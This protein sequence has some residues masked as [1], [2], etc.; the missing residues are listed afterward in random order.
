MPEQSPSLFDCDPM[1]SPGDFRASICPWLVAVLDWL[2][3]GAVYSSDAWNSL[4]RA[5]PVGWSLRMCQDLGVLGPQQSRRRVIWESIQDQESG[6]WKW[7]KRV[8]SPPLFPLSGNTVIWG[9]SA[10]LIVNTSVWP[11]DGSVC[12]LSAILETGD[13]PSKFYLSPLACRGI[14]RRAAKR[15]KELPE[16]LRLALKQVASLEQTE[17]QEDIA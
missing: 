14:L 13:V 6:Q 12:S 3:H 11:S 1:S 7:T 2:E 5:V 9:A 10:A 4:M 8:I 15:G 16:H 17:P